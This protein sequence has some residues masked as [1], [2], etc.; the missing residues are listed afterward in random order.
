PD[1]AG[2]RP[3]LRRHRLDLELH[4]LA[5]AQDVVEILQG[6][7]EV[8]A[9]LALDRERDHEELELRRPDALGRVPKRRLRRVAEADLVADLAELAAHRLKHLVADDLEG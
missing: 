4:L 2:A 3:R 1:D 9:G 6:L 7:G 5:P 8:A